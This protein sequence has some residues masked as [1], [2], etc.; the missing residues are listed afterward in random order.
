MYNKQLKHV[1]TKYI[2]IYITITITTET[3]FQQKLIYIPIFVFCQTIHTQAERFHYESKTTNIKYNKC[4][5]VLF[6]STF[7]FVSLFYPDG[8]SISY[9]TPNFSYRNGKQTDI[10]SNKTN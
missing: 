6:S 8:K 5:S 2:R 4:H 7:F 1:S 10:G 3:S 9:L